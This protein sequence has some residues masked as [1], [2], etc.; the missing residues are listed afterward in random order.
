MWGEYYDQGSSQSSGFS[1]GAPTPSPSPL[2]PNLMTN[3]DK[4]SS[5]VE[6]NFYSNN[7]ASMTDVSPYK[8]LH[9]YDQQQSPL[10]YMNMNDDGLGSLQ[11]DFYNSPGVSPLKENTDVKHFTKTR[12]FTKVIKEFSDLLISL[13]TVRWYSMQKHVMNEIY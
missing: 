11:L 10:K 6:R 4:P 12:K 1:M 2:T 3:Y 5:P 13:Q 8:Y 9:G 7:S